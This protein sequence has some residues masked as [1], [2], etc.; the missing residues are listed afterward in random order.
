[1]L[2]HDFTP[3]KVDVEEVDDGSLLFP[4][5][6]ERGT[7]ISVL[8]LVPSTSLQT[9]RCAHAVIVITSFSIFISLSWPCRSASLKSRFAFI[10]C[11]N[12]PSV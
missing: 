4:L 12:P 10:L 7:G 6:T 5:E 9:L 8:L 3:S 11:G 2:V 1:V